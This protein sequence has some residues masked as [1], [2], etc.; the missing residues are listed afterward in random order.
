M[1]G[2]SGPLG[3]VGGGQLSVMTAAAA[4]RL[5]VEV[6]VLASR[7]DDPAVRFLPGTT[8]GDPT[9]PATL[10]AF[11]RR[12]GVVTFDHELVDVTL[13]ADLERRGAALRPGP[14]ALAVAT[15]K[16]AQRLRFA[17]A[18][19][20]L[21]P[22]V[23]TTTAA[24]VRAAA[25]RLGWPVVAKVARGGYDGRGVAVLRD[26]V[27]LDA[28]DPG[29]A[30][31]AVVEPALDIEAELAVQIARRPGGETVVHPVVRTVQVDGM[32]HSVVVPSGLPDGVE[33]EAVAIARSVATAVDAVGLLAVEL[34]LVDGRLL[35][36]EIAARPHN[37]GHHTIES[38]V[39][40]QFENHVRGVLDLPLGDPSLRV[41]AAAMANVVGRSRDPLHPGVD[42]GPGT[43]VHLYGKPPRPGRKL[44]HVT[45][46]AD[47]STTAE[48]RAHRLADLLVGRTSAAPETSEVL[49]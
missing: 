23:L 20:P 36:N 34:F 19:L 6:A 39:T 12:C 13:L 45:A 7:P 46:V 38:C 21:P 29:H 41:P 17:E 15:D 3:I 2:S 18:G 22:H 25:D 24:D 28:W 43:T 8:V 49:V 44:G 42:P 14:R 11:V 9:D 35:V 32:C 5:G 30:L 31:P 10:E 47:D 48:A 16:Q 40:S 4:V 37:T 26:A 33:A 1:S 27:D